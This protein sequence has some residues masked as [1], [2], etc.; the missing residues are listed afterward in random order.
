MTWFVLKA[1][2]N[3]SQPTQA[4]DADL[5][6]AS[7]ALRNSLTLPTNRQLVTCIRT[8]KWIFS[9]C[10]L[11]LWLMT[12]TCELGPDS[13]NKNQRA[14]Y[15][16]RRS[17]W[18]KDYC[19]DTATHTLPIA[20]PEPLKRSVKVLKYRRQTTARNCDC[21]CCCMQFVRRPRSMK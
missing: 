21:N 20:L 14:R 17:V 1:P 19:L 5:I 8:Q 6:T 18:L 10:D 15:L 13:I 2:L 9:Y 11:E 7:T 4:T 12:F 3:L 16:G